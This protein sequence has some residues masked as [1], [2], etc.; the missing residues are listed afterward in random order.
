MLEVTC[1]WV[2]FAWSDNGLWALT[3]PQPS[4]AAALGQLVHYLVSPTEEGEWPA[5]EEGLKAFFLGK[6]VGFSHIPIDRSGYTPFQWAVLD[7]VRGIGFGHVMHYGQVAYM[8]G[9]PRAARAAGNA[10]GKNRTPVVIPCH[11]VVRADG[12]IGG[13]S[14]K[15]EW[16]KY[17]LRLESAHHPCRSRRLAALSP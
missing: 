1:G 6:P 13:F 10:L 12:S 2:A 16:K 17:L 4:R 9:Y 14:G 8:A 15:P 5:L 7:V 3:L 11:R